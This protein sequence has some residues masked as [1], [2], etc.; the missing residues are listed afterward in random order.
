MKLTYLEPKSC[1]LEKY[2]VTKKSKLKKSCDIHPI[3]LPPYQTVMGIYGYL[4]RGD[5]SHTFRVRVKLMHRDGVTSQALIMAD[6]QIENYYKQ[7][8]E[9]SRTIKTPEEL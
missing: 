2:N 1:S 9:L 7:T 6:K 3:Q 4:R 5:S 8:T